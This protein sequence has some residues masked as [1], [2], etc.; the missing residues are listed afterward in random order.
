MRTGHH[1]MLKFG[2]MT[3]ALLSGLC[4][5]RITQ[6]DTV[7]IG[8]IYGGVPTSLGG[9]SDPGGVISFF[10]FN[11]P[12][13]SFEAIYSGMLNG[14]S[15]NLY[16]VDLG[17][18]LFSGDYSATVRSDG[19]VD[20]LKDNNADHRFGHLENPHPSDAFGT[21]FNNKSVG[22]LVDKFGHSAVS[23]DDRVGLQAAIWKAEYG[24]NFTLTP[25]YTRPGGI[26]AYNSYLNALNAADV[27]NFDVSRVLWISPIDAD[28]IIRQGLV[29]ASPVPEPSSILMA[30]FGLLGMFAIR[31]RIRV[32]LNAA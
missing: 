13:T 26:S 9:S 8:D 6:A 12:T 32:G 4:F 2:V 20:S 25:L 15:A 1:S 3:L 27:S 11:D 18:Y 17:T 30:A 23:V 22:W 5:G 24:D 21:V 28:E 16:C 10:F 14:V 29:A 31:S 19:T 7:T